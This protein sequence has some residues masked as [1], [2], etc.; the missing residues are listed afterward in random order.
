MN[1]Y[2]EDTA[3]VVAEL[4]SLSNRVSAKKPEKNFIGIAFCTMLREPASTTFTQKW[5]HLLTG[6]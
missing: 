5:A 1:E 4:D 2:N 6:K 3:H